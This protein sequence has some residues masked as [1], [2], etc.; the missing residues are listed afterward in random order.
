MRS[1]LLTHSLLSVSPGLHSFLFSGETWR[2]EL[3]ITLS[4]GANAIY[5]PASTL[6]SV[7]RAA[8]PTHPNRQMQDV[9]NY[10]QTFQDHLT[11]ILAIQSKI[12]T[13]S[14]Q[15]HEVYHDF[16]SLFFNWGDTETAL[17]ETA[18]DVSKS[19]DK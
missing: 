11:S 13:K 2:G 16:G 17:K 10:A 3:T 1:F 9:K 5:Q 7:A 12:A 18:K 4:D 6:A 19:F 15:L 8:R 14:I